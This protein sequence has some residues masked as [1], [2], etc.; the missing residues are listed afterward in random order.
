MA[1]V[2]KCMYSHSAHLGYAE[3]CRI[4]NVNRFS[5]SG[6]LSLK[7]GS[8]N[9]QRYPSTPRQPAFSKRRVQIGKASKTSHGSSNYPY[10][11]HAEGSLLIQPVYTAPTE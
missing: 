9:T 5:L 1:F 8:K 7:I 11:P 2:G 10:G 3:S 6:F 4:S